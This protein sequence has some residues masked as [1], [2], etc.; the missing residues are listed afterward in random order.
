M[1]EAAAINTLIRLYSER[2]Q[3]LNTFGVV[4]KLFLDAPQHVALMV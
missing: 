4:A 3:T 2:N 1:N